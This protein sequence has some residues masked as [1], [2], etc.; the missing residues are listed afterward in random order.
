[1]RIK[2]NEANK[3]HLTMPDHE[4]QFMVVWSMV[5]DIAALSVEGEEYIHFEGKRYGRNP[6]SDSLWHPSQLLI[7]MARMART[8]QV[9]FMREYV[10]TLIEYD[11]GIEVPEP[12]KPP[13]HLTLDRIEW[14]TVTAFHEQADAVA[15]IVDGQNYLRLNAVD[16]AVEENAGGAAGLIEYWDMLVGQRLVSE[17][18]A[19]MKKHVPIA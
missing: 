18:T 10:L 19:F 5:N 12:V 16:Y 11:L 1:M 6:E 8:K 7:D 9:K 17:M 2:F 3:A 14:S 15:Y 4:L 13:K